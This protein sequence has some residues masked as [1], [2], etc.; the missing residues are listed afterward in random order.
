MA[1]TKLELTW[2][3][4]GNSRTL[5]ELTENEK[6]KKSSHMPHNSLRN[7]LTRL[8]LFIC[9]ASLPLF[10]TAFAVEPPPMPEVEPTPAPQETNRDQPPV[11]EILLP[12]EAQEEQRVIQKLQDVADRYPSEFTPDVNTGEMML[13]RITLFED[14]TVEEEVVLTLPSDIV[15][16]LQMFRGFVFNTTGGDLEVLWRRADG[17]RGLAAWWGGR[18][19][20]F[21]VLVPYGIPRFDPPFE[22]VL[23]GTAH[24]ESLTLHHHRGIT[25]EFDEEPW[26]VPGSRDPV[27]PV[28]V[29]VD[30]TT[31]LSI[32]GHRALDRSRFM[33]VYNL[34]DGPPDFMKAAEY[35][36]SQGFLPARDAGKNLDAW[37]RMTGPDEEKLK[38]LRNLY[39]EPFDQV[40]CFGAWPARYRHQEPG[41][42]PGTG[43]PGIEHFE[44]AADLAARMVRGRDLALEEFSGRPY[45]EVK[46]E[47]DISRNWAFFAAPDRFDAWKLLA[48]FHNLVADAVRATNPDWRVGGPSSCM[49]AV[50]LNN[51]RRGQ[52]L[53]TFMD[54][55]HRHLDFYSVHFYEPNTFRLIGPGA[56]SA[57]YLFGR[58]EGTF[59]LLRT[60]MHLQQD[61]KPI[62]I[63]EYGGQRSPATDVGRWL[64]IRTTSAHM[65]RYM[66]MPDFVEFSVPFVIPIAFWTRQ[67]PTPTRDS[68]QLFMYDDDGNMELSTLRYFLE[69]WSDFDGDRVVADADTSWV[70][71]NAL[72]D[73]TTLYVAI[74]NMTQQRIAVD[75]EALFGDATPKTI[76][77]TRLNMER[78]ALQFERN[79]LAGLQAIPLGLDETSIIKITLDRPPAERAV[80][81]R[82]T[83]FA[84]RVM[85][86]T[87]APV[88]FVIDAPTEP[89]AAAV[90]RIALGRV[91]GFA[92]D[93][94]VTLNDATP[95]EICL[96]HTRK[97]GM[98]FG[99]VELAVPADELA[100]TN[101]I[102]IHAPDAEGYISSVI[103]VQDT[104]LECLPRLSNHPN[105]QPP[106]VCPTCTKL[107]TSVSPCLHV[108]VQFRALV[109]RSVVLPEVVGCSQEFRNGGRGAVVGDCGD[110]VR[111]I[112]S[113]YGDPLLS[114]R[115]PNA[116]AV[117]GTPQKHRDFL[118]RASAAPVHRIVRHSY[119]R[120]S[121][122]V[123]FPFRAS[124]RERPTIL[125]NRGS[126][127]RR[128]SRYSSSLAKPLMTPT[129][130]P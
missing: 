89:A 22:L 6:M 123:T 72:L 116:P 24:V 111:A 59:D 126:F 25:L 107:D 52:E 49:P 129:G 79:E 10:V 35:F 27:L 75:L 9:L 11:A 98:Y 48:E 125:W 58:L 87:G 97:R 104:H 102:T 2:I 119:P 66:Q 3:G 83:Y 86:P 78:G 17:D 5:V 94:T 99:T 76:E 45:V 124:L 55:T 23:R 4:K 120:S 31:G 105:C 68:F 122:L 80:I 84:D 81:E 60:H 42:P 12:P 16:V 73:E 54:R 15:P 47:P 8:L 101:Q 63:T 43:T 34:A 30:A 44:A 118:S 91:D 114:A 13:S 74:N 37:S 88:E 21:A 29:T 65:M 95:R 85:Q 96:A 127:K 20:L 40:L 51:F 1:K 71:V 67:T 108:T 90:L 14:V 62:L 32:G 77:Q 38:T 57:T 7:N 115:E 18:S 39:P 106:P 19:G 128:Y 41:L 46:N 130:F 53:M 26:G 69:F 93:L 113:P 33:R 100:G 121:S 64:F 117:T 61:V 50:D 109:V 70:T 56:H 28:Q 82:S 110:A 103:L 36:T 92:S 112:R